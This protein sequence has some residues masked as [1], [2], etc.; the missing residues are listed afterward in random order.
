MA[1][2]A[3][4]IG[5]RRRDL[6]PLAARSIGFIAE[7]K[8]L[9]PVKPFSLHLATAANYAPPEWVDNYRRRLDDGKDAVKNADRRITSGPAAT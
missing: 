6:G 4:G 8:Q 2:Y 5:Q 1:C 9:A 3:V 7:L